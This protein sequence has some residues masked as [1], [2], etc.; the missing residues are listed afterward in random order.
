MFTVEELPEFRIAYLRRTGPYGPENGAQMERLKKWAAENGL[1]RPDS[2]VLGIARDDP[3]LTR[4]EDCRYD[5]CLVV[6][7]QGTGIRDP[8]VA[9]GRLAGGRYAVLTVDHT[10][11]G[12][13]RAWAGL[14]DAL[15]DA[16]F[17]LDAARPVLERY[18]PPMVAARLCEICVPVL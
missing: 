6:P 10:A 2:A 12:V 1:L 18:R 5:T 11:E 3:A 4:P 16:G 15:A 7:P 8:E 14:F 13:S 17:G 9:E